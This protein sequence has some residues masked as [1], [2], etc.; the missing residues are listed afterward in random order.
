MQKY[1]QRICL[2]TGIMLLVAAMLLVWLRY[3]HADVHGMTVLLLLFV[4]GLGLLAGSLVR[5]GRFA[6]RLDRFLDQL[7]S[8]N[9]EAG[10]SVSGV[11]RDEISGIERGL[12]ELTEQLRAYDRLRA[13]RVRIVRSMLDALWENIPE[14]VMVVDVETGT[15]ECNS[16]FRALFGSGGQVP[17]LAALKNLDA[18]AGFEELLDSVVETKKPVAAR[19][20]RF[21][22]RPAEEPRDLDIKLVPIK[23]KADTVRNVLLVTAPS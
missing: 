16:A 15:V 2:V 6:R 12:D 1:C 8:G 7:L 14:P 10:V 4:A 5:I 20:V 11:C 21:Q 3:G 13:D 17:A 9:Y 23:D 22:M 18:N 19:N